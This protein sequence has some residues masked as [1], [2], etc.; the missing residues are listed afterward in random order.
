MVLRQTGSVSE[1]AIAFQNITNTF[2]PRWGDH[3]LI[4]V[5][6]QKLRETVRFEM[7]A[8]GAIP[9]TFQTYIAAAIS[10]EHNHAAAAL[11]RN[12]LLP[13]PFRIKAYVRILA[14]QS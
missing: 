2:I 3:P 13:P 10:V 8:W 9:L 5:F 11:S 12:H 6:S 7:T 1:L 4:F 14:N